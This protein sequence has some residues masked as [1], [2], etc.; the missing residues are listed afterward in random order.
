MSY[1]NG[2]THYNLP[3][4]VGTDKRDWTDTNQAFADVDAALYTA[5]DTASTAA[6]N[7]STLDAQ[8]NTPSTGIDARL[9][10]AEQNIVAIDGRLDTAEGAINHQALEIADV[11]NDVEDMI[12]AY[13]E[14]SATSTHA[15]S[16]EDYFIYNNVLY[17]ATESIAVGDTIVPDTNCT[18]TNVTSEFLKHFYKLIK[19]PY[20][21]SQTWATIFQNIYSSVGDTFDDCKVVIDAAPFYTTPVRGIISSSFTTSLSGVLGSEGG[22]RFYSYTSRNHKLEVIQI[23]T[24]GTSLTDYSNNN[25]ATD[26]TAYVYVRNELR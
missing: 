1:A 8:I 7:I 19:V 23:D 10:S 11:R 20:T 16:A 2:T 14:A 22:V 9:T 18:T 3:Q 21:T 13:N 15:Y 6:S 25:P 12:C 5:A 17:Q 4:T 24:N 26:G